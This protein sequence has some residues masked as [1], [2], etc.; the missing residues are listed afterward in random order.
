M[1]KNKKF[2]TA[3][4]ATFGCVLAIVLLRYLE[5]H[6]LN[7]KMDSGFDF[8]LASSL[9]WLTVAPFVFIFYAFNDLGKSL[10]NSKNFLLTLVKISPLILVYCSVI[11]LIWYPGE[12]GLIA[13]I[14]Y[15]LGNLNLYLIGCITAS[16][17]WL[18][19]EFHIEPE[20]YKNVTGEFLFFLAIPH[21]AGCYVWY[22]LDDGCR[23]DY[24]GYTECD[25]SYIQI[26]DK[27]VEKASIVGVS[28]EGMM[29]ANLYVYLIYTLIAYPVVTATMAGLRSLRG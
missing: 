16:M 22:R 6:P 5:E 11:V 9:G 8:L 13:S 28:I 29:A 14:T 2:Y 24:D 15:A 23:T 27:I 21:L 1:G 7:W 10:V 3:L 18:A 20:P 12:G 19:H 4:L 17:V 25:N 26:L